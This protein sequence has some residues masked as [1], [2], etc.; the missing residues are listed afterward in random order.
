M[1]HMQPGT[2]VDGCQIRSGRGG[3]RYGGRGHPEMHQDVFLLTEGKS[4]VTRRPFN[5][6]CSPPR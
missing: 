1:F 6:D 3:P 5:A 2:R 4:L